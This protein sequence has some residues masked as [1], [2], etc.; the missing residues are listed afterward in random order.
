VQWSDDLE[1][2]NIMITIDWSDDLPAPDSRVTPAS[3]PP[4]SG[5]DWFESLVHQANG[6][7]HELL[8]AAHAE[9]LAKAGRK[10]EVSIDIQRYLHSL[11]AN[12]ETL[13]ERYSHRG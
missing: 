4:H 5:R 13:A 3:R 8:E 6:R 9:R 1:E 2:K 11:R 7:H 10:G 12:L